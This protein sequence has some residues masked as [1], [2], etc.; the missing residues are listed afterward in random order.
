M[1]F[2][3]ISHQNSVGHDLP[4]FTFHLTSPGI[5]ISRE[6]HSCM[7]LSESSWAIQRCLSVPGQVLGHD[8]RPL[9]VFIK[10]PDSRV[11]I[12]SPTL[13]SLLLS[14]VVL[15]CDNQGVMFGPA[16]F[17]SFSVNL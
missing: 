7:A 16:G 5:K 2:L 1:F 10:Q 6:L 12:L 13:W 9:L 17:L 8:H 11:S 4:F 14:L 3:V 15:L